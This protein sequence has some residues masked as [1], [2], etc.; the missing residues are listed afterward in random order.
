MRSLMRSAQFLALWFVIVPSSDAA[1]LLA[2]RFRH[3]AVFVTG[4]ADLRWR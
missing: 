4:A 3:A 2:W 1:N